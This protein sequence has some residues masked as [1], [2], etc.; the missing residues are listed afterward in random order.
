MDKL[1]TR[2][3][4]SNLITATIIVL[5]IPWLQE[6]N[7]MIFEGKDTVYG[8]II[9]LAFISGIYFSIVRSK[10][11]GQQ[12]T[13]RMSGFE[14]FFI[15]LLYLFAMGGNMM[16][17]FVAL[18]SIYGAHETIPTYADIIGISLMLLCMG[19]LGAEVAYWSKSQGKPVSEK[20][21]K[22]ANWL[23]MFYVGTGSAVVWD[24]MIIGS[25][26]S[27]RTSTSGFWADMVALFFLALMVLF[28]FQRLFWYEMVVQSRGWKDNLKVALAFTTVLAAAIVPLFFV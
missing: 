3:F 1:T 4:L 22:L 24:V 2:F 6:R 12:L 10:Y 17:L 28:P 21:N 15:G 8:I 16:M 25:N 7:K 26:M 13:G 5:S 18:T 23:I 11:M 9:L 20:R 14:K 27:I 19:G